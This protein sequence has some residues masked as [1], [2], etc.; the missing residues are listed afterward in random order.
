M[1]Q[2]DVSQGL[3]GGAP[4]SKVRSCHSLS[5]ELGEKGEA[6]EL[7]LAKTISTTHVTSSYYT[8]QSYPN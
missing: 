3:G 2:F 8:N 4:V 6:F 7:K 1:S 5:N